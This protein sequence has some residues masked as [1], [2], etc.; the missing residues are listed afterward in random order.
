[1]NEKRR[2]GGISFPAPRK[3]EYVLMIR[4]NVNTP[5]DPEN[6]KEGLKKLCTL[7]ELIEK[8]GLEIEDN[9]SE[10]GGIDFYSLSQFNFTVTVGFGSTFFRKLDL[11]NKCPI[12]LYEMPNAPELGDN[13]PYVLPQTDI[14]LQIASNDYSVNRMVLQNDNYFKPYK[15]YTSR[16]G[17]HLNYFESGPFDI[18]EA[19][20]GWA[21]I[22][23][24]HTGFRRADGRNLMGFYDGISNPYRL[25]IND[26]WITKDEGGQEL[27]D[28]TFMVFQKIEHNL[29]DWHKLD[30]DQQEKW[31]GRSKATG[32][33][34]GTLSNSEEKRLMTD[35]HSSDSSNSK[36]AT[37][38]LS[39]LVGGQRNPRKNLFDPYDVRCMNIYK[40]CPIS[41][42]ARKA[43]PRGKGSIKQ[44]FI[45]RRGFLYMDEDF[46][47]YPKSGVLFISFQND[48]KTF[49]DIKRKLSER[50]NGRRGTEKH[51]GTNSY[52]PKKQPVQSTFNTLTLGG[53]Y[54]FVPPIPD[55]KISSIGQNF[56]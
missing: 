13:S 49:E 53:G 54:Y 17:G 26:I 32:L 35:L 10:E 47:G 3:Q 39:E 30:V 15:N 9:S 31:V 6:V 22:A 36:K 25:D 52:Y 24:V 2:Q 56:F 21:E 41:S 51:T 12:K 48:I 20:S 34:L 8:G 33:L 5:R 11:M 1:M 16:N 14:I 55:K 4:I 45:F 42:H 38:R 46:S 44:N 19:I 29:N 27:A 50:V 7:F 23:D 40:N 18:I 43:N 37:L 28:G